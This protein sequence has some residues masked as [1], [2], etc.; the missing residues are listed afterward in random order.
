MTS[1][2]DE[3]RVKPQNGCLVLDCG[4]PTTSSLIIAAMRC[5]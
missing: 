4:N 5:A 2:C 1:A 3:F